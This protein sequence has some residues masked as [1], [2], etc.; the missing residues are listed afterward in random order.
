LI[1]PHTFNFHLISEQAIAAGGAI[2]VPDAA[3]TLQTAICLFD[4]VDRKDAMANAA[5][6]FAKHHQGATRR[7]VS[8][9][10]KVLNQ[11]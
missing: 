8:L 7:T 3:T 2:R 10:G 4:N 9:I 11:I 5:R 1:G 6:D